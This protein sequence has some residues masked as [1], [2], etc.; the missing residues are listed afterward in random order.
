MVII[1]FRN[2]YIFRNFVSP[3]SGKYSYFSKICTISQRCVHDRFSNCSYADAFELAGDSPGTSD[4]FHNFAE[5]VGL[6][7]VERKSQWVE[8]NQSA[9][10]KKRLFYVMLCAIVA[11]TVVF[12]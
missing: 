10:Q 5:N 1:S 9:G 8:Q 2:F 4:R 12:W 6:A 11:C 3:F 7:S